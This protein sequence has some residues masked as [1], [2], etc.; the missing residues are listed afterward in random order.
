MGSIRKELSVEAT[1]AHVW[2]AIRDVGAIHERL[3]RGFVTGTRLD[4]DARVVT[5]SNGV[6]VRERIVDVND[7][8]YRVAYAIVDGRPS[9]HH[10]SMQ[11]LADGER[12]SRIVWITDLLPDDLLG[13]FG[14]MIEQGCAAMKATLEDTGAQ[15]SG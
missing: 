2:A 13:S 15:E 5:F 12:R 8:E 4:G 11:V 14:S 10:A 9:H 1:R 3:A 6:V 7:A